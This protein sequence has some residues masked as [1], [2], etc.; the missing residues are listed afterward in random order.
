MKTEFTN[1]YEYRALTTKNHL[2]HFV[3]FVTF[4]PCP[5]FTKSGY[6]VMYEELTYSKSEYGITE[7]RKIEIKMDEVSTAFKDASNNH[8]RLIL[9]PRDYQILNEEAQKEQILEFGEGIHGALFAYH[10]P[11][12]LT[13]K[14]KSGPVDVITAVKDEGH[15]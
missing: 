14:V 10:L 11:S 15:L 13:V 2:I 3:Q 8:P 4:S 12:G 9:P 6:V 1:V 5:G 7:P